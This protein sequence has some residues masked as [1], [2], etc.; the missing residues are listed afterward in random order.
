MIIGRLSE[1][2]GGGLQ[3]RLEGFDSPTFLKVH[4]EAQANG[5]ANRKCN[6]RPSRDGGNEIAHRSEG[7]SKVAPGP[8]TTSGRK[9]DG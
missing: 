4:G 7:G 1:W 6:E 8:G 2:S 3:N 9:V 5:L